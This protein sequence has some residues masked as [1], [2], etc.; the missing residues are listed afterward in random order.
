LGTL[1]F[2]EERR[3]VISVLVG[4][5]PEGSSRSGMRKHLTELIWLRMTG[6][7]LL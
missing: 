1:L 7:E 2:P 3:G 5:G 4:G 6:A